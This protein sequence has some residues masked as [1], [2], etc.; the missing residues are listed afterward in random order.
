LIFLLIFN[1]WWCVLL[2]PFSTILANF[3][4]KRLSRTNQ[5]PFIISGHVYNL[6][7]RKR[8]FK[9]DDNIEPSASYETLIQKEC[10]TYIRTI[11]ARYICVWYYP[12]ISTDQEFPEDLMII[13]NVIL[14]RLSDRLKSLNSYDISRLII[15]LKQQ[16]MEQ[17]LHTLDSFEKQRKQ[18]R[19]SKSL[20]EEFSQII[21]FHRSIVNND[22]HAYL[23]AFVELFLT[24]LI[25]ESFHIYSGSHTGREF[26][27]QIV[28]NCIFL[29]LLKQF[30]NPRMIYYLIV[31]LF[32]TEEQTNALKTNENS[33]I[34]Q[35]E[36]IIDQ[37]EKVPAILTKDFG[38][39]QDQRRTSYLERIIY[40]ATI[41]SCDIAYNSMSGAS[42]TVYIIQVIYDKRDV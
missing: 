40:S 18:N 12:L 11:I 28:V 20:A 14:N 35:T 24:D 6:F 22:I 1:R 17:Y 39:Q 32:E 13:F 41:S 33:L 25:P 15:N 9:Q 36:T 29:P 10:D 42:Y 30:S 3:A 5:S 4:I 8:A 31:L 23:K 27:A 26:L 19:I 2:L 16:H 34:T 38:D 37:N 7:F 21:G